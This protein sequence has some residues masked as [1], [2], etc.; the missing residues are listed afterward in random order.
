MVENVKKRRRVRSFVLAGVLLALCLAA[1][2]V[3]LLYF[4]NKDYISDAVPNVDGTIETGNDAVEQ[5]VLDF[6]ESAPADIIRDAEGEDTRVGL[7]FVGLTEEADTNHAVLDLIKKNGLKASFALSAADAL[8]D[9]D[10]LNDLL[11]DGSDLLSNGAAGESNLHTRTVREMVEV[12]LK[13]RESMATAADKAVSLLYCSSTKLTGDVLRAAAVSGY[14]A[15]LA[16]ESSHVLDENSFET[17]A[18]AAAFVA[19][20]QG[21]TIVVVNLRGLVEDIQDED[22]VTAEKPAIDKQPELDDSK[23]PEDEPEDVLTKLGWLT[24]ALNTQNIRTE[25]VRNFKKTDGLTV[26]R[27][28]AEA[29]DAE[30]APVYRSCLTD[31]KQAGLAVRGVPEADELDAALALLK[32]SGC[33]ATFFATPEEAETRSTEIKKLEDSQNSVGLY[34]PAAQL[35]GL[36]RGEVFDTLYGLLRQDAFSS[37][38]VL[39]DEKMDADQLT[40]LRAAARLLNAKL[41]LPESP[42]T[43]EAGSLYLLETVEEER[44]AELVQKASEA[45]LA[46]TDSQT[47]IRRSGTLPVLTAQDIN[48]L[49]RQNDHKLAQVQNMAYTTERAVSFAFYGMGNPTVVADAA[50]RLHRQGGSGTFFVTLDELM[51]CSASIE[52]LLAQGH[53]LGIYYKTSGDYPQTFDAVLN[54]LNSWKKY[55]EWRY[56]VSSDV[57]LMASDTATEDTEEAISASGC[58][59]I[60]NTFL[61]VKNEDREMTLEELPA[62]VERISAMRVMRGAFICFNMDFYTN[63]KDAPAGDT[64]LG[65]VLDAF[66][67]NHVDT[68]AYRSH[69]TG[70]IE[71]ASRFA[72]TTVSHVLHSSGTYSFCS[73]KQTDIALDKNVLTNMATDEE[74]FQYIAERYYGNVTVDGRDK[75]PGFTSE[76]IRQLDK[77]GTFTEDKVIFLTFDDWGTEQSINELLYVLEKHGVKATFFIRTGYVDANPNLLRAIAVQGHQLASHTD[78]HMPL[79]DSISISGTRERMD[80]LTD[81]EALQLRKDLVT[82][83]EKLYRYTGD[84]VVD[85]RPALT[86][87]FRPPTLAVSKAG[88]TQVFDTGFDYSI[89]GAYS[90]GDYEASSY[91]DM[92]QRLTRRSIGEGKYVTIH[93]GTVVVMHMQENAKYTAQALDTMIPYWQQQGYTFARIDDY[94]GD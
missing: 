67:E 37:G 45:G 39:V 30:L 20:L 57:V 66:I 88:L 58:T 59:L 12:M 81:A 49:R 19:G 18:D 82:S 9:E 6:N 85:G 23:E 25:Y 54:Y 63:D 47:V 61:V 21:D 34:L 65:A 40:A 26:L 52:H 87:M 56:G 72:I 71:D 79:A 73:G 90:T 43:M 14:T 83:Y 50:D 74:R 33:A 91:Q 8:G 10:L 86:R 53:E 3:W 69:E 46:L 2:V 32:K 16:P 15:V 93:N 28:E 41:L 75:L 76:E 78:T 80:S 84:V 70:E 22:A 89:S 64:I 38:L 31:Q 35:K 42:E 11:N 55:A 4:R 51:S 7:V 68:L 48:A 29:P 27:E 24:E 92:I 13:S 1:L 60:R 94:L 44:L 62:A 5:A 17:A 36:T 77:K